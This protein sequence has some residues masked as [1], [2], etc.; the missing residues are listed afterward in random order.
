MRSNI[1]LMLGVAGICAATPSTLSPQY[2]LRKRVPK[3]PQ[4]LADLVSTARPE[5]REFA[6]LEDALSPGTSQ[7]RA[8][9]DPAIQKQKSRQGQPHPSGG[10][11]EPRPKSRLPKPFTGL[12]KIWARSEPQAAAKDSAGSGTRTQFNRANQLVSLGKRA[13]NEEDAHEFEEKLAGE[14]KGRPASPVH[15]LFGGDE[16][17]EK[18]AGPHDKPHEEESRMK[19]P[20]RFGSHE[21]KHDSEPKHLP[22]HH[23]PFIE[24]YGHEARP[25]RPRGGTRKQKEFGNERGDRPVS[26]FPF[27]EKDLRKPEPHR[28]QILQKQVP[29][30]KEV[31]EHEIE[32]GH[33]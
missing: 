11:S 13:V 8:K 14:S 12:S 19:G 17:M 7:L 23:W 29:F 18:A 25:S 30:K 9:L 5:L 21:M 27:D 31:D 24:D 28:G 32:E 4:E 1:F 33:E 3:T 15:K 16:D 2:S 6:P 22:E 10:T 20:G 26:D